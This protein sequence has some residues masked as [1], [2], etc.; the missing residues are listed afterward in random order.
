MSECFAHGRYMGERCPK[1][2]ELG[3]RGQLTGHTERTNIPYRYTAKGR[4]RWC[5]VKVK[6]PRRT[7]CSEACAIE[8]RI[9]AWPATARGH[10]SRRDNGVCSLCGTDTKKLQ[11]RARL[12]FSHAIGLRMSAPPP[13]PHGHLGKRETSR[14]GWR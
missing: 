14:N 4:C 3:K 11:H 2:M 5:G 12:I 6:K 1:C 13:H 10:V 7:W 9:R 8:Y